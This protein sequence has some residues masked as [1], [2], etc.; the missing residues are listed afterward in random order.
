MQVGP[1]ICLK[2]FCPKSWRIGQRKHSLR[3]RQG[4]FRNAYKP[5]QSRFH[6]KRKGMHHLNQ[7]LRDQLHRLFVIWL[8]TFVTEIKHARDDYHRTRSGRQNIVYI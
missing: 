8:R 3:C 4:S 5:M 1:E 7:I 2:Q 6:E